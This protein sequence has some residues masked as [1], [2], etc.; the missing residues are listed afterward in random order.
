M[1]KKTKT[2]TVIATLDDLRALDHQ[3]II[4]TKIIKKGVTAN[5]QV[6]YHWQKVKEYILLLARLGYTN[7]ASLSRILRIPD[8]TLYKFFEDHPALKREIALEAQHFEVTLA[9][10]LVDQINKDN[11]QAIQF[12]LKRIL[13]KKDK[14]AGEFVADV[15]V[16]V[17]APDPEAVAEILA[18]YKKDKDEDKN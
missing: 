6:K 1:A 9:D 4:A 10:K 7:P 15:N 8:S 11:W 12:M 2:N 14:L 17:E 18:K 13:D 3:S 5:G 16:V